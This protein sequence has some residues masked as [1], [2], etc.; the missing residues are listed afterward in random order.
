LKANGNL[1]QAIQRFQELID[2]YPQNEHAAEAWLEMAEAYAWRDDVDQAIQTYRAFAQEQPQSPLAVTALRE[3]AELELNGGDLE[4][5]AA[6]FRDLAARYPAAEESP[7]ALYRAAMLDYRRAD[8]ETARE[9]WQKLIQDYPDSQAGL[10]AR[11]WLGKAWLALQ[12]PAEAEAAFEAAYE[13]A[14]TSY[15]GV[16]AVEMLDEPSALSLNAAPFPLDDPQGDQAAAEAWLANWLPITRTLSLGALDP[17]IAQSPAFRRGDA[18][19]DIGRR[20]DA[21]DEFEAVQDAWWDDPL[22]MY[23]LAVAFRDRGLYRLSIIC[24]ERLTALSPAA[25]RLE[26]PTFVQRLS[27]PIYYQELVTSEAQGQAM[28]PLLLF[29][30][31]R[32]ES[33]FEPSITSPADARGLMQII[34]ATGE[35]IAGRLAWGEFGENDLWLPYVNIGFGAFYLSVQL[36]TFDGQAIPALAAYNAGPGRIHDWLAEAPD[37]DLFVE[38]MPFSEPRRYVRGVYEN[39][40]HYRRLYRD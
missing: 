13:W 29:A 4:Q 10:A 26:M 9:T 18:L 1:R 16:R 27:Y 33:L 17:A 7:D 20:A 31:I 15:Y 32:Q 37:I 39:Y 38:T 2:S 21:L 19:L 40:A 5:A 30:L 6:S 8:Y 3:A 25:S 36:S 22:A 35:W 23:Q 14:P 12:N 11:F 28:D 34:P 24:A